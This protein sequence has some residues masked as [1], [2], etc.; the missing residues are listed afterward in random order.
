MLYDTRNAYDFNPNVP[1][2]DE[3]RR[4]ERLR[5]AQEIVRAVLPDLRQEIDNPERDMNS[6][7]EILRP[8]HQQTVGEVP[9]TPNDQGS[10]S[11]IAPFPLIEVATGH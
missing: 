1:P 10:V 7:F 11:A 6:V 3:A 9:M 4:Q 2:G 5:Q 8:Y